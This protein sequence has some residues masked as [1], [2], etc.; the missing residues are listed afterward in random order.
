[1]QTAA[2][3]VYIRAMFQQEFDHLKILRAHGIMQRPQS[4]IVLSV[5][6]SAQ[7]KTFQSPLLI[8]RD[9]AENSR[10]N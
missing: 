3:Q 2:W 4:A 9:D 10:F 1:M 8:S 6:I 5:Y 7:R